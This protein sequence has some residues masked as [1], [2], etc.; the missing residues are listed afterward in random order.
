MS[1]QDQESKT[2]EASEKK[3]RDAIERGNTPSSK[4]APIFASIAATLIASVFLIRASSGELARFLSNFLSDPAGFD[5]STN[6]NTTTLLTY[7][8]VQASLFVGPILLLFMVFGLSASFLQHAP[9]FSLE[10]IS[11]QWSRI[12]PGKGWSRIAGAQG[13]MEFGKSLAK[14][15]AIAV[16]TWLILKSDK[17][18][19]VTAML[20]DPSTIPELV[21]TIATRLLSAACVATIVIV[22][23]DLVWTQKSWR[24][25]LRMTKQEI[26]DEHKQAEGDPILK[27]R[28][29]SLA[30]DRARSRMMAAVPRATMII[31]NPTHYA[32]ALRYVPE[33]GGAPLVL[34]KGIDLIALKIRE[35]A[36][37]NDI[38]VIEDR[39]LARSLHASV[40]ID[41]MIPP[42]FYKVVAELLCLVYARKVA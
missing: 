33:E 1:E 22:A 26:K 3:I 19:V 14:F 18:T 20:Q 35:I 25:S 40:Q 23:A 28:R 17:N 27:S 21:L 12:S 37:A 2:E 41:Q 36:E 16:T 31:A 39:V 7:V 42:E 30:R 5:I 24:R 38:P 10:R 15:A 29:L 9:Q 13:L 6:K 8:A 4:E 11:P 34:A 32:V